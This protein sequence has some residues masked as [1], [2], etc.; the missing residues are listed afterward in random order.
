MVLA[1][2]VFFPLSLFCERR[3]IKINVNELLNDILIK[4]ILK[5]QTFLWENKF[6]AKKKLKT[7]FML[8][9]VLKT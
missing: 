2:E 5:I 7:D 3:K 4:F 6:Y 8:N 1:V 9:Q